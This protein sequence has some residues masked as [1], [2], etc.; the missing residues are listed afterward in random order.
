M[1]RKC[2]KGY[3]MVN[4]VCS[5]MSTRRRGRHGNQ[6]EN[7]SD[8]TPMY[9]HGEC[10]DLI[11]DQAACHSTA[12]LTTGNCFSMGGSCCSCY[13][14]GF[15]QFNWNIN[16]DI[17]IDHLVELAPGWLDQDFNNL[18]DVGDTN[19]WQPMLVYGSDYFNHMLGIMEQWSLSD[20]I[21]SY[22]WNEQCNCMFT[23]GQALQ[24]ACGQGAN[25]G[26]GGAGARWGSRSWRKGGK[27][28]RRR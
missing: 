4:G 5:D 22:W 10:Y 2:P 16:P 9:D 28:R 6:F 14:T 8:P 20:Q 3:T 7:P 26:I 12:G 23:C 18:W 19:S 11:H 27:I 1:S 24:S 13:G 25:M 15:G 17:D 21:T